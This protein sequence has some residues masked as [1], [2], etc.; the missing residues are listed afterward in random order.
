MA[1]RMHAKLSEIKQLLQRRLHDR[2]REV[3]SWLRRVLQGFYNYHAVPG[4]LRRLWALRYR[5][6]RCW[7]RVMRRR[8]QRR[9][10]WERFFALVGAWLPAPRVLHPYPD[11][12]FRA[13]HSR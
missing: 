9:L 6:L 11:V 8:S 1:K 3:G 4:N 10:S 13:S 12:R 5:L 7:W 2:P